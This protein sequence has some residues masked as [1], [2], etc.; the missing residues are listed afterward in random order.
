[1]SAF[2][3]TATLEK[4]LIMGTGR[5]FSKKPKTRPKKSPAERRRREETH[6]R[7]LVEL[8][9]SEDEVRHLT[10]VEMRDLLRRPGKL[11]SA[12]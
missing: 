7:R 8:G 2:D 10:P 5:K 4:V 1:M 11:A 12:G 3:Q 6:R 9:M